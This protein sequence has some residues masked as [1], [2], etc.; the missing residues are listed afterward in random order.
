MTLKDKALILAKINDLDHFR[1]ALL[2]LLDDVD[3]ELHRNDN[4]W[5]DRLLHKDIPINP[6]P[7]D[8]LR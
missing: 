2:C 7:C 1:L 3:A 8:D 4:A 5:L 6:E